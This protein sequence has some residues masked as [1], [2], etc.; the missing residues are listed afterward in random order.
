MCV[1][2]NKWP[3]LVGAPFGLE[4]HVTLLQA[5]LKH[6]T[7]QLQQLACTTFTNWLPVVTS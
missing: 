5:A 7:C 6:T 3:S 1:R 4:S 2:F